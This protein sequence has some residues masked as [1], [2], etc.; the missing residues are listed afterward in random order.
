MIENKKISRFLIT[1]MILLF[2]VAWIFPIWNVVATSMKTTDQ[3]LKQ[4]PWVLPLELNVFKQFFLNVYDGLTGKV[5]G[6]S[7]EAVFPALISSLI[8]GILGAIIAIICAALAAYSL[9]RLRVKGRF[10]LFMLIFSGTI[11]PFQVYLIPLFKMYQGLHIY[12]TRLGLILFYSAISIPFCMLVL[13]NWFNGI[14]Q[15]IIDAAR[16]DGCGSMRVFLKMIVP[17]SWPAFATLF[18]LQFTWIWND[19]I[20]GLTLSV[21]NNIKPIM[22][23]LA[24]LQTMWSPIPFPVVMASTLVGSLPTIIIAIAFQRHFFRGL[25]ISI[26]GE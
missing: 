26:A 19:L 17:L 16:I 8:Y 9:S 24:N 12:D 3:Y 18:L 7:G 21:S 2:V 15:E 10:F 20:F 23:V 5:E 14:P 13:R 25:T 4:K 22:T 1:A 6:G 11:F